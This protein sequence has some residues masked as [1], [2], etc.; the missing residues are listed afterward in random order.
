MRVE[1]GR[2]CG[3]EEA[4]AEVEAEV[5]TKVEAAILTRGPRIVGGPVW[6]KLGAFTHLMLDTISG[7]GISEGQGARAAVL[8]R[9]ETVHGCEVNM[10]KHIQI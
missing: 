5:E 7:N 2:T 9:I 3:R 6:A 8:G 1:A 10:R 4:D